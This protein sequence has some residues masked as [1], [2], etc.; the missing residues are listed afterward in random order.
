MSS[1]KQVTEEEV[2]EKLQ[3][4][5]ETDEEYQDEE[6]VPEKEEEDPEHEVIRENAEAA[7]ARFNLRNHD[8]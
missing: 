8:N 4:Y 6:E 7:I 1:D 2:L 3:D 5:L